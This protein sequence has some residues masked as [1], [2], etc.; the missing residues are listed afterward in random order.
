MRLE[1]LVG[2]NLVG[3][4]MDK[5]NFESK[6]FYFNVASQCLAVIDRRRLFGVWGIPVSVISS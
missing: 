5:T 6:Q 1:N 3:I 2:I 4:N